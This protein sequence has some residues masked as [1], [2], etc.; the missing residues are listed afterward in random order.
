MNDEPEGKVD[1][2]PGIEKPAGDK[3]QKILAQLGVGSRREMERWISDGRVTV[4]GSRAKLG[5][6][7]SESDQIQV[8]HKAI[9][10]V[11]I[12]PR[13]ILLNKQEGVIC[14]RSDPEG[15]TTCFDDLPK[16]GKGRWISIGRLDINTSG[17]LLLTNDGEFANRMMH[18]SSSIDREYA[19]RVDGEIG[20]DVL[21]NLVQ[22]VQLEDGFAKFADIRYFNG[23][24]RNH[25]YH[26]V[27]LEG[28]NREVRRLFES[29]NIR[30]SRLKR[31]RFG[32]VILPSALLRGR[33]QEL[34][35][36]DV[37]SM[38]R[39][40]AMAEPDLSD[41]RKPRESVL[42][43]Y[44]GL[45]LGSKRKRQGKSKPQGRQKPGGRKRRS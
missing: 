35:V 3:L 20:P 40:V 4:N 28:R 37:K 2:E 26:V 42:I 8:D 34:G 9:R 36:E 15:R 38:Y 7:V 29:Q 22:G 6:R 45:E 23:S 44:P 19:V 41:E 18:P 43:A 30:I 13:I 21:E 24:G 31:V 12:R 14:T 5:D 16:L 10:R 39:L 1:I 11:A 17:L 25:W 32:P 33:R 27:V